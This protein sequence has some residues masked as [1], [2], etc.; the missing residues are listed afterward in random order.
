MLLALSENNLI[1]PLKNK[2][3]KCPLCKLEVIAKCGEIN[4]HHWAHK[5]NEGCDSWSEPETYW[6]KSWKESFPIHT[7]EVVI[8]KYEKKH[9][10]DL[11][12]DKKI[13]IEL[14]NSPIGSDTIIEREKFYGKRLLWVINGGRFR[15]HIKIYN[16]E[17]TI[18]IVKKR[19]PKYPYKEIY[20]SDEDINEYLGTDE[21]FRFSWK[22]PIRSW[23]NSKRPVF[24]DIN[25]DY[26]LWFINGIGTDYGKFKV[27]SKKRFI[28]KY[29]GDYSKYNELNNLDRLFDY[30]EFVKIT[31]DVFYHID[32]ELKGYNYTP[33]LS[34][35]VYDN[36]TKK[37]CL[38]KVR[39]K[40]FLIPNGNSK[41]IYFLFCYK[42]SD[43]QKVGM[44][45][46]MTDNRTI[47]TNI[48]EK[49]EKNKKDDFFHLDNTWKIDYIASIP[50]NKYDLENSGQEILNH[51][52]KN[53]TERISDKNK[54]EIIKTTHNN[55]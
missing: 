41:G 31:Y 14:Q 4:I 26:I 11:F 45:A 2:T 40:D 8:E 50:L 24:L 27:Y 30:K 22:Y 44:Y 23:E 17:K 10:A 36:L 51:Y 48:L 15:D 37:T 32:L 46:S 1:A 16:N 6:H 18:D 35:K 34:L 52:L 13:V 25:E 7:R 19:N 12:T 42:L 55:K 3:A 49:I 38:S 5:E 39:W 29:G 28:E 33:Y 53:I 21:E 47:R 43:P 20:L 9:F 54:F